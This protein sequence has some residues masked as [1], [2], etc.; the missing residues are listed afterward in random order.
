ME[1]L[2]GGIWTAVL[3][4]WDRSSSSGTEQSMVVERIVIHPNFTDY[5]N[6]IALLQLPR[7]APSSLIPVCLPPTN[8]DDLVGM[9]FVCSWVDDY[10]KLA[11]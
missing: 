7:P 3:G 9:R 10:Y 8:L 2:G 4:D 6:D 11:F 1:L 5:K